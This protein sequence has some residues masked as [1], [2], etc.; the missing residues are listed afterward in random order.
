MEIEEPSLDELKAI[1][2]KSENPLLR[3]RNSIQDETEVIE[4]INFHILRTLVYQ[5]NMRYNAEKEL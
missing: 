1:V 3:K 4:I 2:A 5:R